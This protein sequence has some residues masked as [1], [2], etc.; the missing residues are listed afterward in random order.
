[1]GAVGEIVRS[2]T[3]TLSSRP[4]RYIFRHKKIPTS[5]AP[6]EVAEVGGTGELSQFVVLGRLFPV[7]NRSA[8]WLHHGTR[9]RGCGVTAA[10][11]CSA[12]PDRGGSRWRAIVSPLL[13]TSVVRTFQRRQFALGRKIPLSDTLIV[14]AHEGG[15]G[16]S[17]Q[18]EEFLRRFQFA[19][20][21]A[22]R[23]NHASPSVSNNST[24]P[25]S[26]KGY[27]N[28]IPSESE[29]SDTVVRRRPHRRIATDGPGWLGD[30]RQHPMQAYPTQETVFDAFPQCM[31]LPRALKSLRF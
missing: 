9:P 19:T 22:V 4:C 13:V 29:F 23:I 6:I 14:S 2:E 5:D 21:S 12:S 11:M 8:Q 24:A 10:S 16:G 25:G 1:L 20:V 26:R 3:T 31:G 30:P 7:M 17:S 18:G 15:S 28:G 27:G